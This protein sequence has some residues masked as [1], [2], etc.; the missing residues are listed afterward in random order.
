MA[1]HNL[2]DNLNKDVAFERLAQRALH[3]DRLRVTDDRPD[4]QVGEKLNKPF[5]DRL[6]F[7]GEH[8]QMDFF[9][10]MEGALR[11]GERAAGD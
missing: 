3:Q 4:L 6:F 9:G 10:Y 1:I 5:H 11:S 8:T 7:A 2:T